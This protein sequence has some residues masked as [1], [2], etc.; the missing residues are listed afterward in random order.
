MFKRPDGVFVSQI[1]SA[2]LNVIQSKESIN[3][4]DLL[5]LLKNFNRVESIEVLANISNRI[6][7]G[8][9]GGDWESLSKGLIFSQKSKT[10]IYQGLLEYLVNIFILAEEKSRKQSLAFN[11]NILGLVHI[12]A[13]KIESPSFKNKHILYAFL[14]LYLSQI[15]LQF[16][17]NTQTMGRYLWFFESN[18]DKYIFKEKSLKDL[19]IET[20]GFDIDEYLNI[21]LVLFAFVINN[22]KILI[23]D[24]ESNVKSFTTIIDIEK[25]KKFIDV[26]AAS[27]KELQDIDKDKN[28][29]LQASNTKN[30]FNPLWSKPI[31]KIEQNELLVPNVST[32]I[33][34]VFEGLFWL[35]EDLFTSGIYKSEG[36]NVFRQ[37]FGKEVFE[38]YVESVV[39][40]I[41]GSKNVTS[42]IVYKNNKT[43]TERRF[44]DCIAIDGDDAYLFESKAYQ[45]PLKMSMSG[46]V[47]SIK[48]YISKKIIDDGIKKLNE[49]ISDIDCVSEL[50]FIKGKK[51]IPVI[52][53]YNIPHIDTNMFIDG[54]KDNASED[55]K[56]A[57]DKYSGYLLNISDLE[58][59]KKISKHKKLNDVLEANIQPS[60]NSS[61]YSEVMKICK[62]VKNA[63]KTF[64]DVVFNKKMNYIT[65]M[66]KPV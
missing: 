40:D 15:R 35:F 26:K 50:A 8:S 36:I 24:L 43:K 57:I 52:V 66:V 28:A 38:P 46:D 3:E 61:F 31:I 5:N 53:A 1:D 41:F 6:W 47:E 51:I 58:V 2:L 25:L 18:K 63:D 17:D 29:N 37:F 7:N 19:F 56:E 21:G 48:E 11:D 54:L 45:I 30:R 59:F 32:Y 4:K 9:M 16:F 20:T 12:Y 64:P 44:V 13:N 49:K 42:E 34:S 23:G 27:I 33:Q 55:R 60:S 10:H 62:E 22:P 65:K 14:S 39:I